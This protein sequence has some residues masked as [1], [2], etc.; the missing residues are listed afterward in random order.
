M[1]QHCPRSGRA[2]KRPQSVHS[3]H[4]P[5]GTPVHTQHTQSTSMQYYLSL[6]SHTFT[7]LYRGMHTHSLHILKGCRKPTY[8]LTRT[9]QI[10]HKHSQT[11]RT[12]THTHTTVY[13]Y[14]S[15]TFGL[16]SST[17][18]LHTYTPPTY[19]SLYE[20]N[21]RGENAQWVKALAAQ[22]DGLRLIPGTQE[23]KEENKVPQVFLNSNTQ[24]S[25]Q[26]S[27]HV[28]TNT[29]VHRHTCTK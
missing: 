5:T 19:A 11:I 10:T 16:L 1:Q 25:G 3:T 7:H 20:H 29:H 4:N 27:L 22:S 23:V 2:H 13:T 6:P 28:Y 17:H 24:V 26:V 15:Y 21:R 14:S 9:T 8:C 12:H 18:L